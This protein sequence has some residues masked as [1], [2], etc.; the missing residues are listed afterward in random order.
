M[1]KHPEGWVITR[2]G[3]ICD[4]PKQ[5]VPAI[6][7][8]FTYIDIASINRDLKVVSNP[9]HLQGANAP[10]R[11]RKEV[12]SGDVIVSMTRPNLN[13]VALID[14]QLHGSFAS[15]GFDV[16]RPIEVD[17]RWIFAVVRSTKFIESMCDKVQGALYPAIK[18][19]DIREYEI[20]LP[21]VTEQIRIAQK[22]DE[23]L[24]QVDTLRRRV[25]AIPTL[26]K[27][28]RQSVLAAA[29]SGRLTEEWR[30]SQPPLSNAF[31]LHQSLK[32]AHENQ[33]GHERS[34]ASK[35]T[36]KAHNLT[37]DGLPAHWDIAELRD[38]CA[39]G[40]PITYGILKPGPELE[41][42]V[43][44]IRVADFPGNKLDLSKIKKTS[45]EID[46]QYKRARLA[47]GDL[48]LSIRGS[49]GRLI[50]IPE[51][52]EGANITQD[53]ARLSISPLIS[54][55]FVYWALLADSTQLRMKNATRGVAIR[56]INI[57]DVRALQ[58]PLPP[59]EEQNEIA[60]RIKQLFDYAEKVESKII[61]ALSRIEGLSQSILAKAFRGELTTNWRIKNHQLISG[62]NSAAA[63]L[64]KIRIS[65]QEKNNSPSPKKTAPRRKTNKTMEKE[66]IS[67]SE[68]LK[69]A[70]RP[71]SGQQLLTATGYP[72]DSKTDQL[73][74]FFL[75]IRSAIDSKQIFKI[76]RDDSGQDWF[77]LVEAR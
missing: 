61:I 40:R 23:L 45:P 19:A 15:T 32:T 9:Q 33:G 11:A 38:M 6:D 8:E 22:L 58:V 43:P 53:T 62:E 26:L 30:A 27:R 12:E 66:I 17:P 77:A 54:T 55:D 76:K 5:R 56:G 72:I 64:E 70:D 73:E 10:S 16:L 21:P 18:A 7:E 34:N 57:G 50:K 52:L 63:L 31:A 46:L 28:F 37:H 67:V 14:T 44:Y 65:R 49:V 41:V 47:A 75:D 24:S 35:P 39:P 4:Q 68:A 29:F 13:A 60:H 59:I 71:L 74:Q 2:L 69:K 42:G 48:L 25:D 1:S 3:D 51:Q 20:P 36:E